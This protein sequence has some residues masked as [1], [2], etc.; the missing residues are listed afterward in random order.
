M[1]EDFRPEIAAVCVPVRNE[2]ALLPDVLLALSSQVVGCDIDVVFCFLLD[3]CHDA[4]AAIVADFAASA[5]FPVR[6]SEVAR[7]NGPNAGRARRSAMAIGQEASLGR[8]G[9]VLLTTDADS[10]PATDWIRTA[11]RALESCDIVA[12]RIVRQQL[13]KHPAQDRLEAYL[14]R[15]YVVRRI[16]DPLPWEP[17]TAHHQVGGANLAFRASAY[18]AVGGFETLASGED[19]VI[20]DVAQRCGLR[21]RRDP[22]VIVRTSDRIDGRAV[23][24]FADHLRIMARDGAATQVGHPDDAAWQFRRHALARDMF[25]KLD[26]EYAEG[27]LAEALCVDIGHIRRIA[28]QSRNAE[29]FATC[30]VPSPPN[31]QRLISLT[32]AEVALGDL[33]RSLFERAA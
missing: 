29:A 1:S 33:E 30:V 14:E 9:A 28:A 11:C 32:D 5:P 15:L 7:D 3:I 16:F 31:G 2:E 25:D 17:Q 12:G 8:A 26:Q 22:S 13:I 24:G 19:G 20:V 18:D 21:V 27:I 23:N 10:L 4:S 6:W